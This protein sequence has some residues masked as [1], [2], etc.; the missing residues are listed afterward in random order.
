MANSIVRN[1]I[2]K[3]TP[4]RL[5]FILTKINPHPNG[6]HGS[7]LF[8][9]V[10]LADLTDAPWKPTT[11]VEK[12]LFP[13]VAFCAP[14]EGTC[15]YVRLPDLQDTELVRAFPYKGASLLVLP[16][17]SKTLHSSFSMIAWDP[18]RPDAVSFSVGN[19]LRTIGPKVGGI[20]TMP[21][22]TAKKL[23]FTAARVGRICS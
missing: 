5:S 19:S 9:K 3:M 21:V 4:A 1:A 22:S 20:V 13:Y 10:E 14:L 23:G 8:E 12:P 2:L 11:L 6:L 15:S 7:R 18:G 16:K 17:T